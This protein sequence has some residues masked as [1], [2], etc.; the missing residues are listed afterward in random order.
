LNLEYERVLLD[1]LYSKL[2]FNYFD[3]DEYFHEYLNLHSYATFLYRNSPHFNLL[4]LFQ[5]ADITVLAENESE[6]FTFNALCG[7]PPPNQNNAGAADSEKRLTGASFSDFTLRSFLYD[8][9]EAHELQ[10]HSSY[11]IAECFG[12]ED[13]H[14][15][16]LGRTMQI[17]RNY[18]QAYHC[19]RKIIA[20][21]KA[22]VE[23]IE[24][25]F[26][27]RGG[28]D[29]LPVPHFARILLSN[30]ASRE[31]IPRGL[32]EL[33]ERYEPLRK[34]VTQYNSRLQDAQSISDLQRIDHELR[35]AWVNLLK[36]DEQD[37]SSRL[38]YR[39]WDVVKSGPKMLIEF[40]DQL[41][42]KDELEY[43]IFRVRGLFD[44]WSD[45]KAMPPRN[46]F[47]PLVE[48]VFSE[49]IPEK[50]YRALVDY[51][52]ALEPLSSHRYEEQSGHEPEGGETV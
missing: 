49:T 50:D 1:H 9:V 17:Q 21:A 43:P 38:V 12:L 42:K 47:R 52:E 5:R 13:V 29:L 23:S 4:R 41:R 19:I 34:T 33:R 39:I 32:I 11:H 10:S 22:K 48:G 16:L 35:T 20:D 2:S 46:R 26:D 45:L 36:K 8:V 40:L 7:F 14:L 3:I 28:Y 37:L 51:C 6:E 18:G 24:D 27:F 31:D 15:P 44:L 25:S 30:C